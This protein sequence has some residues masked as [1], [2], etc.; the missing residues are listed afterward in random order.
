MKDLERVKVFVL[1]VGISLL[2]LSEFLY[3]WWM[4]E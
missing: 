4:Q 1:S 3:L 2:L